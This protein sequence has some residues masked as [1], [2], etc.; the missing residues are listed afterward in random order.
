VVALHLLHNFEDSSDNSDGLDRFHDDAFFRSLTIEEDDADVLRKI[1]TFA[2]PMKRALSNDARIV[3]ALGSCLCW[4][5]PI[6]V[7]GDALMGTRS[8]GWSTETQEIVLDLACGALKGLYALVPSSKHALPIVQSFSRKIGPRL[9][10]VLASV[11]SNHQA[12]SAVLSLVRLLDVGSLDPSV[13]SALVKKV[14]SVLVE[15]DEQEIWTKCTDALA[16]LLGQ[17]ASS[18]ADLSGTFQSL[19]ESVQDSEC[20]DAASLGRLSAIVASVPSFSLPSQTQ[21]VCLQGLSESE[22]D[23]DCLPFMVTLMSCSLINKL[24][25][26]LSC[27]PTSETFAS[28]SSDVAILQDTFLRALADVIPKCQEVQPLL[29]CLAAMADL[30]KLSKPGNKKLPLSLTPASHAQLSSFYDGVDRVSLTQDLSETDDSLVKSVA[31]GLISL[32]SLGYLKMGGTRSLQSSLT[33]CAATHHGLDLLKQLLHN[34]PEVAIAFREA[35]VSA[36]QYLYLSKNLLVLDA[37]VSLGASGT[38]WP[39]TGCSAAAVLTD[40]LKFV[41]GQAET[42]SGLLDH[43]AALVVKVDPHD[44]ASIKD[45]INKLRVGDDATAL[46]EAL[47]SLNAGDMKRLKSMATKPKS[48]Q[49]T[50]GAKTGKSKASAK[51]GRT[52][53]REDDDDELYSS[54]RPKKSATATAPKSRR[55]SQAPK[56]VI[57]EV[58]Q[59]LDFSRIKNARLRASQSVSDENEATVLTNQQPPVTET[60]KRGPSGV[61]PAPTATNSA[62]AEAEDDASGTGLDLATA[63]RA[64]GGQN[65]ARTTKRRRFL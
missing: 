19:C 16:S 38:C 62:A 39:S 40:L 32:L 22:P 3:T 54:R 65:G 64:M 29:S 51:R 56:N 44:S 13:L 60:R 9:G 21:A 18:D 20:K 52:G 35:F 58:A 50:T 27:P 12:L 24:H 14:L 45:H 42:R 47:D 10:H 49:K 15:D 11:R 36:A 8:A 46:L 59:P 34:V 48:P 2:L 23:G 7:D 53:R 43:V 57:I 55:S 37:L 61:A 26:L 33:F 41:A 17:G 31:D 25:S 6:V 30:L 28:E 1:V 4:V 63:S 5:V